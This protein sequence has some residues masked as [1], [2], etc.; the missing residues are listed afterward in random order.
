MTI[1]IF[2]LTLSCNS[3]PNLAYIIFLAGVELRTVT[4]LMSNSTNL[5]EMLNQVII[6]IGVIFH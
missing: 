6:L 1:A 2:R 3:S 5:F 4:L